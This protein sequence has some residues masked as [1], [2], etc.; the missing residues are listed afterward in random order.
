M[1]IRFLLS[2]LAV[3]QLARQENLTILVGHYGSQKAD[4]IGSQA[5][6]ALKESDVKTVIACDCQVG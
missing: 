6:K 3:Y 4:G 2:G 1:L 5:I